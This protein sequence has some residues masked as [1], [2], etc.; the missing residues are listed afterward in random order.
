M[1][2]YKL[3]GSA[4]AI[5]FV[6][7]VSISTLWTASPANAA[8]HREAPLVN[9]Q[10]ALD[11]TDSFAFLSPDETRLVVV[12]TVNPFSVPAVLSSYGFST[13]A[14][15]QIK[16][17]NNGDAIEDFVV[18]CVFS[19]GGGAFNQTVSCFGP[20][21]PTTTGVVN[22]L[23]P[24]SPVAQGPTNQII[25]GS[26]GVQVFAGLREDPFVTDASQLVSRII[27]AGGVVA[28]Q[29][30]A[31]E[32]TSPALGFL[33]GRPIREDGTSGVDTF[34]GFNASSIIVS[35]PK[36]LVRGP[37]F[38]GIP[39]LISFWGTVNTPVAGSP[40]DFTQVE[41][42]GQQL[43]AT[44]FVPGPMRNAFNAAIPQNDMAAF[45]NLIPGTLTTTDNDGTGNTI[46]GRAALLDAVGVTA[47]PNGAPL[48]L[49]PSFN[50]T[51]PNLLRIALLPDVGRLDLDRAPEDFAI[52]AFGLQ[53]GRTP[54]FDVTDVLL[55]LARQLA[56]IKF[57][58]GA[59]VPGSGPLGTRAALNCSDLAT[60]PQC[61][62]RRILAVLQGTDFIEADDRVADVSDS[63]N[64]VEFPSVTGGT[65]ALFAET[66]FPFFGAPN[67]LPGDLG[68]SNFPRQTNDVFD[69]FI[70]D[71]DGC[72]LAASGK[73]NMSGIGLMLLAPV[74]YVFVRRLRK[75]NK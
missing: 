25:N 1:S 51:N 70:S 31:R 54:Q 29:D 8:D 11:L 18:Q 67:A 3:L 9:F 16:I 43:V 27:G 68:T 48:L 66:V 14:L 60:F 36:N 30:V 26:N 5:L 13:T 40:G 69:V 56:D 44:V 57:P 59:G 7:S 53:N 45:G 38:F 61:T 41:R 33:R 20:A 21:A 50:N 65:T 35:F 63:G 72:S 55:R 15:Y 6:A 58:D 52:G 64:I 28:N 75:K 2:R 22:R 74:V 34:G 37:G 49:P 10:P 23:L 4:L 42:F 73:G 47:L 39:G 24:G 71:G 12:N 46:A 32:F 62:D 19:G 17:D